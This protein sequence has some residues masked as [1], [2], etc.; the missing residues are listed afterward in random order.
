MRFVL[1][2]FMQMP[3]LTV[4]DRFEVGAQ[5]SARLWW[6]G[7]IPSWKH[8]LQIKRMEPLEIYTCEHGG[9]VR[10]WNHRLTFTPIDSHHCS[11]TDEVETDG[12]VRGAATRAFIRVMFGH[13][14]R[15]WRA[16]AGIL[17]ED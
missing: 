2:P 9:P 12:G 4:P 13:R 11:Y 17:A 3:R 1:A 10:T 8:Y 16:L 5:G 7:L 6:F 14:H 15:R